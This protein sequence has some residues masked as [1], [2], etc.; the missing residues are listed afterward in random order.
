ME[1][2]DLFIEMLQ[3][4]GIAYGQILLLAI[5]LGIEHGEQPLG[6]FDRRVMSSGYVGT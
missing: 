1:F 5:E 6:R 3:E 2:V 4:C